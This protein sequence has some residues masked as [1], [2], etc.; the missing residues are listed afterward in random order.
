MLLRDLWD[1]GLR[2][3]QSVHTTRDCNQIDQ[4][5]QRLHEIRMFL[6]QFGL[7]GA[8]LTLLFIGFYL[9]SVGLR[10]LSE[11]GN[12]RRWLISGLSLAEGSLSSASSR[13]SE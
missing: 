10:R 9:I 3:S 5:N 7:G 6:V 12:P 11:G 1:R 4:A 2:I 8:L 13:P